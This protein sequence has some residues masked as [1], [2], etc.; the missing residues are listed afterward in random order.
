MAM[1]VF[2]LSLGSVF[3]V[4]LATMWNAGEVATA[5]GRKRL[6]HIAIV[7]LII[8]L[9]ASLGLGMPEW[10]TRTLGLALAATT[11]WMGLSE[12]GR[13]CAYCAIQMVFGGAVAAG[14]PYA[15]I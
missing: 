11:L 15:V 1:P 6:F 10:L 14:L 7:T 12:R 9:L 4:F 5:T 13:P 8:A 3:A 2:L